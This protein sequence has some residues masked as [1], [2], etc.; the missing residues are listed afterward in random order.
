[1]GIRTKENQLDA[2]IKKAEDWNKK[3]EEQYIKLQEKLDAIAS[4]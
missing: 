1:M 4:V 3:M 2:L